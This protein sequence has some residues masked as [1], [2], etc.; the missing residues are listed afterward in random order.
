MKGYDW[1]SFCPVALGPEILQDLSALY[2]L[3]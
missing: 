3:V 1:E 2:S